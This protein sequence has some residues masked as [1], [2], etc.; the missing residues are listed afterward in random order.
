MEGGLAKADLTEWEQL[1]HVINGQLQGTGSDHYN[2]YETDFQDLQAMGANL[3]KVVLEWSR[4]QPTPSTFDAAAIAHY[5]AVINSLIAKGIRPVACLN[6]FSLPTW[7]NSPINPSTDLDGW[8]N[9]SVA[10]A[11]QTFATQMAQEFGAT[12]DWWQTFNEPEFMALLAYA[13]GLFP[14]GVINDSGQILQAMQVVALAHS[15]AYTAIHAND[16]VD[17][18]GDGN[19]ALVSVVSSVN[20]W[21]ARDPNNPA[22]EALRPQRRS[23]HDDLV[24][25]TALAFW[26]ASWRL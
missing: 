4:I 1:G 10:F 23:I 20:E 18:D 13:V 25:A 15:L 21:V 12:I 9:P 8:Q 3:N 11:F 17:A 6:H 19:A 26:R 5:H 24:F 7:V 16:T 2:R 14:P 22:V